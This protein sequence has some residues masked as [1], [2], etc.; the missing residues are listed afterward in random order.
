MEMEAPFDGLL[1]RYIFFLS[2]RRAVD[3]NY[4]YVAKFKSKH[5]RGRGASL[6]FA[7]LI[8]A[9]LSMRCLLLAYSL[10]LRLNTLISY[11]DLTF[12]CKTEC[13]LGMRL[14]TPMYLI[15]LAQ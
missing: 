9:Y 15:Q 5:L 3:F 6:S 8:L 2:V 14:L 4:N 7:C 12:Q 1:L 13:D 11:P 10:E